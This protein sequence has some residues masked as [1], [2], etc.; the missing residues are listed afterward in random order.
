MLP[1]RSFNLAELTWPELREAIAGGATTLI[2]P[3]GATEQHGPH[4]PL[5]TDTL[6]ATALAEALA[7]H[8]PQALVAPTLPIG[9]SDEHS[10]FPGL[11]GVE[12]PILASL[13]VAAARRM[14]AW[15]VRRLVL[16]SAHGG[17]GE[18]LALARERLRE[19]LPGLVLWLPTDLLASHTALLTIA[20]ADGLSPELVGLHAGEG[21]TSEVLALRPDLVRRELAMPG[22]CGDM[23]AI[24]PTLQA[25]G[26]QAVTPNG[27]LGDPRPATAERGTR[28]LAAYAEALASELAEP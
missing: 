17:N 15:G 7:A 22:Y 28:Y 19:E 23:V 5:A 16:L 3:L 4:L 6:R 13:L 24:M 27:V 11:L 26:L 18:A 14:W 9:C 12:A 10:G 1:E 21:E 2:W 25:V 20:A 8:L